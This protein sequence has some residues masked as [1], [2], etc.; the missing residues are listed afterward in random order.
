MIYIIQK[1]NGDYESYHNLFATKSKKKAI[2]IVKGFNSLYSLYKK[3]M[4]LVGEKYPL[5]KRTVLNEEEQKDIYLFRVKETDRIFEEL[6]DKYFLNI[7]IS[8][9]EYKLGGNNGYFQFCIPTTYHFIEM[10]I[11]E[12]QNFK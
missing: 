9:S 5:P 6:A 11:F 8:Y 2:E 7:M 10:K 1:D 4:K 12:Y 3:T